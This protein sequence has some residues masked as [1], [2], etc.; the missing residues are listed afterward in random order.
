MKARSLAVFILLICMNPVRSQ[1]ITL[2]TY[3]LRYDTEADGPN[4]WDNRKAFLISQLGFYRPDVFG[5]QEGLLHQLQDIKNGLTGY[6]FFGRGREDGD[7]EGEFSAI[8]YN[9]EALTLL[10]EKTFWLSETPETPSKGWDAAIKRVCTYGLFETTR[11]KQRFFVF[12]THLDHMGETARKESVRL[13]L[14]RIP[15]INRSGLPVVLM[16]DFNLEP[17][18]AAIA[19]LKDVLDDAHEL[20]GDRPF[21]PA[22]TFNGFDVTQPATRRIDYLFVSPSDF[23]LKRYAILTATIDG[24]FPSDH[25]PVYAQLQLKE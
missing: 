16:G 20:A 10:A 12:N 7:Q 15:A 14:D 23:R 25:F 2:L 8:F 21:G 17:G 9:K 19:N 18:H 13:L 24:R 11:D 5:T 6:D 1:D 3:N 22:G 4:R